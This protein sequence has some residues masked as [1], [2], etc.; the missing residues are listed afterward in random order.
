MSSVITPVNVL[1]AS[2][3]MQTIAA[4]KVMAILFMGT[5][6]L[7]LFLPHSPADEERPHLLHI[8]RCLLRLAHRFDAFGKRIQILPNQA[9]HEVVVVGIEPVTG[10]PDVVHVTRV[11]ERVPDPAMF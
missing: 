10:Q 9:D 7:T 3:A 4:K 5:S 1:G 8:E 6:S 11:P 2:A